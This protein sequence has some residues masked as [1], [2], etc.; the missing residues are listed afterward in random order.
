MIKKNINLFLYILV[1]V[2]SFAF[3]IGCASKVVGREVNETEQPAATIF[4]E[5]YESYVFTTSYTQL[6]ETSELI[7]IGRPV[8]IGATINMARDPSDPSN[9]DSDLFGIGQVYTVVVEQY[10]EGSGEQVVK[11]VQA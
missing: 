4:T 10:L 3:L 5:V 9:P 8:T 2:C 6:A 11:V 1:I 7:I